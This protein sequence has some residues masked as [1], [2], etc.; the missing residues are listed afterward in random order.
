MEGK[1]P[2]GE[3]VR[4]PPWSRL[5]ATVARQDV[6]LSSESN[7]R[8]NR[9]TDCGTAVREKPCPPPENPS[10]FI[11]KNGVKTCIGWLV[12]DALRTSTIIVGFYQI[13]TFRFKMIFSSVV[14]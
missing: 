13:Y 8:K 1:D 11:P 4:K 5:P 2:H 10:Y 14:E 12:H 3:G 7:K 6:P 9:H